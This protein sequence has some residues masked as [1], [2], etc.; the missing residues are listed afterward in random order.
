[1]SPRT[2]ESAHYGR[3]LREPSVDPMNAIAFT[4]VSKSY[5]DVLAVDELDLAIERRADRRAARPQRRRQV[6]LPRPAARPRTPDGGTVQRLRPHPGR[7][8]IAA[9]R[10]RRDAAERRADP[11]AHGRASWSTL[12]CGLLPRAACGLDEVL[13]LAGPHRARRSGASTSSP[14]ARPSGSGSPSPSRAHRDLLVLDEPT[15]AM[16][17]ESRQA[18]WATMRDQ[19]G[20]G[21]T[22]LFATHYLEE[23]DENADR[24]I[25]L[26]RG[27]VLADGTAAEIKAGAG[28]HAGQLRPR[29]PAR[30]PGC[31]APARRHRRGGRRGAPPRCAPP[32]PTRPSTALYAAPA[33][34][35]R[36]L[37]GRRRRPGTG[38]PRPHRRRAEAELP[39]DSHALIKLEITADAAQPA[40]PVLLG[41]LPVVFY[42]LYANICRRHSGSTAPAW[43]PA[44]YLMVSMAA[45]GALA[46]VLMG[47]S[48]PLAKERQS[49]WVRQ[50]RL[51]PLPSRGYH[52]RQDSS[53]A[54]LLVLPVDRRWSA[55]AAVLTRACSL[56]AWQW[57]ALIRR[58]LGR[59]PRLRRARRAHRL[60]AAARRGPPDHDDQLL[61]A[62][63]PRRPVDAR[64]TSCP[65][66][67]RTIAQW[68][69]HPPLRRP[70][71]ERRRGARAAAV[72]RG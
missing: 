24:V 23:A 55:L 68:H 59:Q 29:R 1:M 72:G 50:L 49:G 51:T 41:D 63:D 48:V 34:D 30:R 54:V 2:P 67:L 11:R 57:V 52:R 37:R 14:A 40:V 47:T 33:L 64:S 9:G 13:E 21:R 6:H 22:V 45:F 44:T 61:R 56:Q 66:P 17:V 16:D 12:V 5:G 32:T 43:T 15:T 26:A 60:A 39:K 20:R 36:D 35:V 42:L 18:F 58:D 38:L 10:D 65:R 53:A 31:D 69:A 3:G 27:R 70:R 62:V 28:G 4:G 71:L 8:A 19:A 7:E 25:V 46:A